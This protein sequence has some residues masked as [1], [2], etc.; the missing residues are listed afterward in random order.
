M[1]AVETPS[2]DVSHF[3]WMVKYF[4]LD[5]KKINPYQESLKNR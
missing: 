4:D 1:A 3:S 2:T 5:L